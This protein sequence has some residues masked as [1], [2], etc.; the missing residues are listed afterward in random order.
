MTMDRIK[1]LESSFRILRRN[2]LNT[3]LMILGIVVGI[4]AMTI[5][6]ALGKGAEKQLTEKVKK[7]FGPNNILI[8]AGRVELESGRSS[9]GAAVSLKL[10]DIEAIKNDIPGIS[11]YDVIQVTPER[12]VIF[13]NNNVSTSVNGG[14]AEGEL[15]WRRGV[16]AGEYF[17]KADENSSA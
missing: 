4:A 9:E 17:S 13:G 16:I 8:T 5:T 11:M 14:M 7:L 10:E 12:D 1:I 6:F 15:V 3:V 2:K